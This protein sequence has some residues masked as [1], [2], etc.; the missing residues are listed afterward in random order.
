MAHQQVRP[1]HQL[2]RAS[3]CLAAAS[4][5]VL[6]T[7]SSTTALAEPR[8]PI[9]PTTH[10]WGYSYGAHQP[11]SPGSSGDS[12]ATGSPAKSGKGGGSGP[13]KFSICGVWRM[14][15]QGCSA[16]PVPGAP[17]DAPPAPSLTP[18]QLAATAWQRLRLPLPQ[19]ATAPP[20][21]T[22]GLVGLPEWFWTT[23]WSSHRDRVQAGGVW[24]ELTAR[25]RSLTIRPGAGQP[26]VTCGGPGT[27]YDPK[28]SAAGQHSDCSYTY[29]RS[30]AGLPGAAYQVTATVTWGG[31]WV[32]SDGTGG[33]LPA[34]SRSATFSVRIAEGQAVTK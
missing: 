12:G 34:L 29:L 16:I 23:N 18:A 26:A 11:G 9:P 27:V 31:A 3:G 25:P 21:G 2:L 22:E 19:V 10:N 20:R 14:G 8:N 4:T 5:I 24:A 30:S 7:G 6:V 33:A 15:I 28:R 1:S 17:A 32:G 13:G